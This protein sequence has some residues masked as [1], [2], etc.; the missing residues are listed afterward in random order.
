MAEIREKRTTT[1]DDDEFTGALVTPK[2][3]MET[4]EKLE[5]RKQEESGHCTIRKPTPVECVKLGLSMDKAEQMQPE[6][7]TM[8]DFLMLTNAGFEQYVIRRAYNVKAE[9]WLKLLEQWGLSK[10]NKFAPEAD[11]WRNYP[12]KPAPQPEPKTYAAAQESTPLLTAIEYLRLHGRLPDASEIRRLTPQDLTDSAA[13]ELLRAGASYQKMAGYYGMSSTGHLGYYLKRMGLVGKRMGL[14]G[15]SPNKRGGKRKPAPD[16]ALPGETGNVTTAMVED[17][18]PWHEAGEDDP[19]LIAPISEADPFIAVMTEQH[20]ATAPPEI[21]EPLP[22]FLGDQVPITLSGPVAD[23]SASDYPVDLHTPHIDPPLITPEAPLTIDISSMT[24]F[25]PGIVG[26]RNSQITLSADGTIRMTAGLLTAGPDEC[27][28][29]GGKFTAEVRLSD[30]CRTIAIR[31]S[32]DGYV[33]NSGRGGHAKR[34]GAKAVTAWAAKQL[35][36]P[37]AYEARWDDG[38]QAYVGFLVENVVEAKGVVV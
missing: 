29:P 4:S 21:S 30:D 6:D 32:P 28:I 5:K 35:T 27:R 1:R 16:A 31:R 14:A 7:L 13:G 18:I 24:R 23:E 26:K 8:E 22:D 38:L 25:V 36:L 37:A 3:W 19:L 33:F 2:G 11:S 15:V 9:T 12:A 17:A 34:S 20:E 10:L